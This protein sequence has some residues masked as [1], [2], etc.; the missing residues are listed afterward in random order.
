MVVVASEWLVVVAAL[1]VIAKL[2]AA[3]CGVMKAWAM[4]IWMMCPT[5]ME[6]E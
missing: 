5:W 6:C 4:I 2:V 1:V 3:S